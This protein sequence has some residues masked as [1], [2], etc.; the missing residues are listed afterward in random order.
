[1]FIAT[2]DTVNFSFIAAGH[3]T[4]EAVDNLTLGLDKHA[5]QYRLTRA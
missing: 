4:E 1:M 5:T 2:C 3:T